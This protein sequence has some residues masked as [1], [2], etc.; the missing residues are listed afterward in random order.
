MFMKRYA[1]AFA[2][3]IGSLLLWNQ[4]SSGEALP[5]ACQAQHG[6]GEKGRVPA[7]YKSLD[8]IKEIPKTLSPDKFTDAETKAAYLVAQENPKLLLQLPC[9]CYCDDGL[10]HKSLLSCYIDEHA[11]HCDICRKEAIDGNRLQKEKNLSPAEIREKLA[12]TN[13]HLAKFLDSPSPDPHSAATH[14]AA[15]GNHSS[16][17]TAAPVFALKDLKGKTVR[18]EDYKGKIVLINF[19]ATWCAP[20]QSEMP[21]LV[22]LQ[23]KYRAKGL[24][25][26][27]VTYEPEKLRAVN[28]VALKFKINYPLLFGS[29]EL[30]KQYKIEEVLPVTILVDR[31]GKIQSQILGIIDTKD[32]E[33]KIAPLF[34]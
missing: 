22:K 31:E 32:I 7:Y 1:F 16:A 10:N 27:G 24:Q 3:L 6:A 29:E 2:I 18:L 12:Q 23:K 17:L 14:H 5:S 21:E 8:E 20:C 15:A 30:S 28:R 26:L 19:W 9:Y 4:P 33:Q 11:V 13:G 25:I 34:K